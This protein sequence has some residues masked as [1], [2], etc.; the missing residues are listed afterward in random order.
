VIGKAEEYVGA[1][2]AVAI[3]PFFIAGALFPIGAMA[4][5]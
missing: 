2:P 5:K 4:V 3:L 1:V